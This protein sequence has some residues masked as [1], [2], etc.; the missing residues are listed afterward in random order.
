VDKGAM[1]FMET[2][3]N[4]H[5]P[6]YKPGELTNT[7]YAVHWYDDM[8]LV[9]KRYL[10]WLG[11]DTLTDTI[12]IGAKKIRKVFA[13]THALVKQEAIEKMGGLPTLIGEVGIPFDLNGRKAYKTGNFTDQEKALNRSL[14]AL[15][16]NL[17]SYTLWNYT[18]DN[19]N[20]RGDMWND[21]DL[22][23]FS[24][25]QQLD[26]IDIDSGG[27]AVRV[28]ARPFPIKTAGEPALIEFDPFKSRFVFEFKGNPA[29]TAPTEIYFPAIH[30]ARGY[31]VKVSDGA[32]EVDVRQQRL[33]Y[34][35]GDFAVHRIEITKK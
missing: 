24:R 4:T 8:V 31:W 2:V 25:D 33:T 15:D 5:S 34:H 3:P 26:P 14:Q 32:Y 20:A 19:T 12:A 11:Y 16:D 22:S 27:R 35:S 29:V 30:Y 28:F 23:L 6:E 17:L 21:E 7:V 1:I 18:S 13:G 9:L 10:P